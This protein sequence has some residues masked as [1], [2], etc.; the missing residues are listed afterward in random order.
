MASLY[1]TTAYSDL[2]ARLD[3]SSI[4]PL[5]DNSFFQFDYGQGPGTSNLVYA[6]KSA[7][8]MSVL[9]ALDTPSEVEGEECIPVLRDRVV[10]VLR[11][12]EELADW[13]DPSLSVLAGSLSDRDYT[14]LLLFSVPAVPRDCGALAPQRIAS[15]FSYSAPIMVVEGVS[16]SGLAPD[17]SGAHLRALVVGEPGQDASRIHAPSQADYSFEFAEIT[18]SLTDSRLAAPSIWCRLQIKRLF[19]SEVSGGDVL[20]LAGTYEPLSSA[21]AALEAYRLR[22]VNDARLPLSS[23]CIASVVVSSLFAQMSASGSGY[24]LELVCGGTLEFARLSESFDPFSFGPEP[25]DGMVTVARGRVRSA[26][27]GSGVAFSGLSI[28]IALS[29]GEPFMSVSYRS[30]ELREGDESARAGSFALGFVHS[31]VRMLS[32]QDAETPHDLGFM[33]VSTAAVK[34]GAIEGGDAWYGLGYS[35]DLFAGCAAEILFAQVP[36][37]QS[38][39]VGVRIDG[40]RGL[41][42][43]FATIADL[44]TCEFSDLSL[45]VSREGASPVYSLCLRGFKVGALGLRL[46]EGSAGATLVSQG[47]ESGWYVAY[48]G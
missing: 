12:S 44:F 15:L 35:F 42:S 29:S 25:T 18:A 19:D 21:G 14:G 27:T 46:P 33:P 37:R 16:F 5:S 36:D 34:T 30:I 4:E 38:I 40:I 9:E 11:K 8:G 28:T 7:R 47:G 32:S 39:Y 26:P 6:L 24:R 48:G 22:V 41:S 43:A 23:G 10:A 2:A 17:V 31:D 13:G 20:L 1:V 3:V 45:G